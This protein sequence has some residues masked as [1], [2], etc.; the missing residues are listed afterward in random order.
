M[1]SVTCPPS[2]A[3]RVVMAGNT[4]RF[5]TSTPPIAIGV[6]SLVADCGASSSRHLDT[7]GVLES[8]LLD[9]RGKSCSLTVA[10]RLQR[11]AHTRL[12][13]PAQDRESLLHPV[14]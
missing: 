6:K 13:D 9:S 5:G 14:V 2:S 4:M 8:S 11:R 3:K 10:N 7:A 1:A 12:I